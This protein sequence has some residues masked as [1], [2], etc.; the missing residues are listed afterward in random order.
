MKKLFGLLAIIVLY[1]STGKSFANEGVIIILNGPSSAGKSSIQKE[2]QKNS[3]LHFIRIGI[4]T[5][6]DALIEEPDLSNF[7]EEK[8]FHQY[9]SNGEYI[10]GVELITDEDDH[11][12]VPLYIGPAGDRIIHGMHRSISEY[13]KAGNNVVVD[14]ILYK[15][16]WLNDLKKSLKGRKYYMVGVHAPLSVIEERELLRDTSPPGHARS[17]YTTVHQNFP[18]DLEI[19]TSLETPEEL[20]IKVLT[21]INEN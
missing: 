19:D 20:A 14:Y 2:I 16:E 18:Y 11:P 7:Q 8:Q 12:I 10:R 17:H 9:T 15:P 21:L 3:Q 13:A 1:F 4:D 5:F 6:F